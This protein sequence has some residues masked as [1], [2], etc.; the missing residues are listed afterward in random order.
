VPA[1]PRFLVGLELFVIGA[2]AWS[3]TVVLDAR[4]WK[5]TDGEFRRGYVLLIIMNQLALLPYLAAGVVVA[6]VGYG[7]LYLLVPS[8]VFS[9]LKA[10][11][12]SW[13]L[14]VEINR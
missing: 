7:G 6:T 14:L 1:Q 4:G 13:V 2:A 8:I 5:G 9:L 11:L 3:T 10:L 12:D